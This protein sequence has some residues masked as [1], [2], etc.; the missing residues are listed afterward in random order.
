MAHT[1]TAPRRQVSVYETATREDNGKLILRLT[2]AILMLMHGVSKM[3]N[4]IEP[5]AG[6]LT[7]NGLPPELAYGVYLGEVLA[8]LFV[9]I[10]LWTRPAA[11]L[12]AVN[13]VFAIGLAHANDIFA[14][15]EQGGWALELQGFYLFGSIAV[16]LLGAGA[17]SAGG[18]RGRWN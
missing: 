16:A 15:G 6:M 5:I 12:M 17:L 9:I 13:M 11:V 8:P 10:G 1:I 2:V 7:Q 4:G 3:T 18:Q 14:L